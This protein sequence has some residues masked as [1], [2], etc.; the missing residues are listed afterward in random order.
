MWFHPG[1]EP[2][3]VSSHPLGAGVRTDEQRVTVREVWGSHWV[4]SLLNGAVLPTRGNKLPCPIPDGSS[5]PP[6]PEPVSRYDHTHPGVEQ[7]C[8]ITEA[9]NLLT[10]TGIRVP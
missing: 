10:S 8:P 9:P 2:G 1:P 7:Q 3:L 6:S 5:T 4:T